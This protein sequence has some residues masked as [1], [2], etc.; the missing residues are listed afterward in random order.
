MRTRIVSAA[1]TL[2]MAAATTAAAQQTA[3]P[4]P[5]KEQPPAPG[6]ARDFVIPTP[7]TFTLANGLPVTMVPFG[8]VPKV[9]VRLVI[10]AGNVDEQKDQVW[11]ADLLGRML[12][13]GT[14]SMSAEQLAGE[15][16]GMG[17][18]LGISVGPDTT[19][20]TT[21][22]LSEQ[23]TRAVALLAEVARQPRL[24]ASELPR[25]KATLIRELA[26][27]RTSPQAI[28]SEKFAELVY[29]DHPYGRTFP[30]E[31]ML[32]GYTLEQVTA[33][34]RDHFGA[35]R[36]RLYVAGV[37]D[38]AAMEAAV[39]KAFDGWAKGQPAPERKA[40][41]GGTTRFALV[42]RAGA[43]QSTIRLGLPV[44][45]PSTPDWIPLVVTNSLL[46]G[47][48][49]SRITTNIRE[50]KGYTYSPFSTISP[51]PD[52][53]HWVQSADVTT[54]MTGASL[55][56]IFYEIDR[57]R[58]EEPSSEELQGI[59][60]NQAGVF[61]VQNAS[62]GG[63][64]GQLA[65]VDLYD[66]GPDYLTQYVKRVMAVSPEAVL[67]MANKYLAPDEMRLVV[68]GDEKTVK[69]Q[70]EPFVKKK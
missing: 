20:I 5:T 19:T 38:R 15:F 58:K 30:T 65:F 17:G 69:E 33:F 16:A 29:G 62:R 37:F 26:V 44:A 34:H 40:P 66:L 48:F 43:P 36:A 27:Q 13:E 2:A 31:A 53:A 70:V 57:L 9:T 23:G 24:P 28:A 22:V 7:A 1:L 10:E 32:D 51:H 35:G 59:K 49:A 6:P 64:I 60:N 47:S 12:Q 45:D 56:E 11:L 67:R 54:A 42:D 4:T 14:A 52:V 3:A 46:G 68:V 50:N 61:V 39:R 55:K 41:A 21:D 63:V 8:R 25:L 18:E